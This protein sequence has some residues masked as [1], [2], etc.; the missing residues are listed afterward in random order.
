[1]LI[2]K[3]SPGLCAHWPC[4]QYSEHAVLGMGLFLGVS[5]SERYS[6]RGGILL[7]SSISYRFSILSKT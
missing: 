4:Y 3:S 2:R 5:F 7:K 6:V 1:M